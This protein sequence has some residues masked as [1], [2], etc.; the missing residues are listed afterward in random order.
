MEDARHPEQVQELPLG[1][2]PA[3]FN[4]IPEEAGASEQYACPECGELVLPPTE[5][6]NAILICSS[7]SAQFFRSSE[8]DADTDSVEHASADDESSHDRRESE[9]NAIRIRQ[10]SALRRGA[11]RSRSYCIIAAVTLMVAAVK[12]ALMTVQHVRHAGLQ[13]RPLAYVFGII[14]ASIGFSFFAQRIHEF[15]HELSQPTLPEPTEP[16]DFSTLSDGS[17]RWRNL[18]QM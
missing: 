10:L 12:L 8:P 2:E 15:N 4:P 17:Q 1:I 13:A 3:P 18:E 11:Y 7:C 5:A 9:L 16:P 6:G 14:A